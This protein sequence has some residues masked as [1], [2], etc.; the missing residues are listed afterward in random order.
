[1]IHK[2]ACRIYFS[3]NRSVFNVKIV[4]NPVSVSSKSSTILSEG[5]KHSSWIIS[6]TAIPCRKTLPHLLHGDWVSCCW[7]SHGCN[8]KS[9]FFLTGK[10]LYLSWGFCVSTACPHMCRTFWLCPL[11]TSTFL[12]PHQGS[13]QN[14]CPTV[15]GGSI[16][17]WKTLKLK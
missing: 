10:V 4:I 16:C 7:I 1:M 9:L 3:T 2:A 8:P 15:P 5:F 13:F 17:Q 11:L 14:I 12:F 6:G